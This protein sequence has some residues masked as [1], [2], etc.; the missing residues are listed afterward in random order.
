M[1]ATFV[2]AMPSYVKV[3]VN[4]CYIRDGYTQLF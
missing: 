3:D 1:H 4:A 2:M